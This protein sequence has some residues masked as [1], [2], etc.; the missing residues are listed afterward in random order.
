MH[1]QIHCQVPGQSHFHLS[2]ISQDFLSGNTADVYDALQDGFWFY[3]T[4]H[5]RRKELF[6]L[7]LCLC[8]GPSY[9]S[10]LRSVNSVVPYPFGTVSDLNSNDLQ[11][12]PSEIS[13]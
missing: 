11:S 5:A 9:G 13:M 2:R 12:L 7:L 4:F 3:R 8:A 10:P 1:G 6:Q